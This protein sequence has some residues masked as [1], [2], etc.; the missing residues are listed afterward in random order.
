MNY[1]KTKFALEIVQ[2][3]QNH[4][5]SFYI[6]STRGG[7]NFEELRSELES[8]KYNDIGKWI[9]TMNEK[10]KNIGAQE[11]D[12]YLT[13]C[14]DFT[15]KLFKKFVGRY[16]L[17]ERYWFDEALE[18]HEHI[19]LLKLELPNLLKEGNHAKQPKTEQKVDLNLINKVLKYV[20]DL[21]SIEDQISVFNILSTHEPDIIGLGSQR[22]EID[23]FKLSN[24]TIMEILNY[25][26]SK[27]V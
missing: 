9:S 4:P 24:K 26:E 25:F 16:G 20:N 12:V 6:L 23:L 13:L 21:K 18:L 14:A 22:T 8:G 7:F 2:K 5:L 19:Q 10:I 1:P 17:D 27:K 11:N 15:L 3:L